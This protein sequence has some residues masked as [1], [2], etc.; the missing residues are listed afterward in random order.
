[1]PR[2]SARHGAAIA[3]AD[4]AP[5]VRARVEQRL[6]GQRQARP[7]EIEVGMHAPLRA[8]RHASAASRRKR[9]G[10][11]FEAELHATHVLYRRRGLA[12]IRQHHPRVVGRQGE[13][14]YAP[15]GA[16]C[17][18][19]GA[20]LIAGLLRPVLFDAKGIG[21]GAQYAH[22]PDQYHQL[23]ELLD[24]QAL[25]GVAFL[26]L[27]DAERGIAYLVDVL[28]D[29]TA[30][31]RGESIRLRTIVGRGSRAAVYHQYRIVVQDAASR[32]WDWRTILESDFES[33]D[34]S[35]R[36]R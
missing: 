28:D 12:L 26:L 19:G 18:F 4:L 11:G 24:H 34:P 14:R 31:R 9:S 21:H 23:D 5:D 16:P 17:D 15:G 20:A 6:A 7:P 25:G 29:L 10:T 22:D 36:R 35:E 13:M 33:M 3:M 8:G 2:A 30:L 32:T 27:R 1:M